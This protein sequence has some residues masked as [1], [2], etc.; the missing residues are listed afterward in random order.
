[1]HLFRDV[2]IDYVIEYARRLGIESPLSRDLSL[3]LGSS[4]LSLLELTRAYAVFASGGRRVVPIFIRR[5]TDRDGMVLLE[6]A[7]LGVPEEVAVDPNEEAD[8][9][10]DVAAAA[11]DEVIPVDPDT[12]ID[13]ELLPDPDQLISPRRGVSGDF[14]ASR[15]GRGS[16]GHRPP[17]AGAASSRGRQDRHHQ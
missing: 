17:I 13:A 8:D 12:P 2:G 6:N 9:F 15:G 10:I 11:E 3:A 1:M 16:Q 7:V 4:G 14:P 5:V